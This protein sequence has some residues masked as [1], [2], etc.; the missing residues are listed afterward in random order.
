MGPIHFTP[1]QLRS[2]APSIRKGN[3]RSE[4]L[5][6]PWGKKEPAKI[7]AEKKKEAERPKGKSR[8]SHG[9]GI[10]I[11]KRLQI[12][13]RDRGG[14][15]LKADTGYDGNELKLTT[16]WHITPWTKIGKKEIVRKRTGGEG[17]IKC[18]LQHLREKNILIM[19]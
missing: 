17:R 7:M 4:S 8:K 5:S 15:P 9:I 10:L 18:F 3:E 12:N 1:Q 6:C 14:N 16:T 2:V 19:S 11:E 13:R